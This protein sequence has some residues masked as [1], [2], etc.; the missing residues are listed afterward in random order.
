MPELHWKGPT[1]PS[2]GDD[3]LLAAWPTMLDTAGVITTCASVTAARTL[4]ST[5]P[6]GTVTPTRPAYFD[7]GGVFYKADG[8]KNGGVWILKPWTEK[9]YVE[10]TVGSGETVTVANN[11]FKGILKSTL[12]IRPYDRMVTAQGLVWGVVT[13][14]VS[15][16]MRIGNDH[17]AATLWQGGNSQFSINSGK[18]LAG[19][20]PDIELG[21][22]GS[23]NGGSIRVSV[24]DR[25][26]RLI[27]TAEPVTMA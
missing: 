19:T 17:V 22:L 21:A 3:D 16:D 15:V 24:E 6:A 9:E 26:V 4:L 5:L 20:A 25:W 1:I 2:A 13:G 8:T 18:I 12:P 27:V 10:Q 7:I 23:G 14:E 11:Q